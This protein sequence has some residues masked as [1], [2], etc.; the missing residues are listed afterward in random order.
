MP[1][2]SIQITNK[3][4]V[5]QHFM[6]FQSI[7]IP[8]A[9][10]SEQCFMNVFQLSVAVEGTQDDS[11]TFEFEDS[12]YALYGTKVSDSSGKARINT[13][14]SRGPV[15]LG[16]GGTYK[17]ITTDNNDGVSP[18]WDDK[19]AEGKSTAAAGQFTISTDG[20][21]DNNSK[22]N[23]YIGVGAKSPSTGKVVPI[24]TYEAHPNTV[25]PMQP[26]V[27]YYICFGKFLP[28]T[29]VKAM[30]LG[31]VLMVD[32]SNSKKDKPVSAS[33]TLQQN[34]AYTADDQ[35]ALDRVGTTWKFEQAV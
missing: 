30:E 18:K 1:S 25:V 31:K 32:F 19:A 34:N 23:I 29:L 10:P 35:S 14:S 16:P 13:S 22:S 28:G 11:A 8:T 26:Q 15:T 33:F 12:Y 27:K 24:Q 17:V 4:T 7:P 6:L 5:T 3:S 9:V 21:F 20:S 2:Y